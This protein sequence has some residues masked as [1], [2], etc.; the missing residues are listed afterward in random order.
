MQSQLFVLRILS[1]CM[2]AHWK[3]YRDQLTQH[4]REQNEQESEEAARENASTNSSITDNTVSALSAVAAARHSDPPPLDD[5]LAKYVLSVLTRFLHDVPTTD[6]PDAKA[7]SMTAGSSTKKK[8][9]AAA[10]IDNVP[11][12]SAHNAANLQE[13]EISNEIYKTAGRVLFYISASNW[14]IV[15]ARL[16]A[17]IQHLTTT[18][19]DWPETAELKLLETASLNQKRLGQVLTGMDLPPHRQCVFIFTSRAFF[20]T[21][22]N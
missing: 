10:D 15:F 22:C 17:R 9:A 12:A 3:A 21:T 7:E 13:V 19:D 5:A 2:E 18:N 20:P 16:K 14:P 1:Q 8:P 6:D 4:L 11:I